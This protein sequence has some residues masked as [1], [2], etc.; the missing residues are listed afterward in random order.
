MA[1]AIWIFNLRASVRTGCSDS[2]A[3]HFAVAAPLSCRSVETAQLVLSKFL[4]APESVFRVRRNSVF[5]K[6]L[7]ASV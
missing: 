2:F 3:L 4:S 7:L 5:A 1:F 6:S